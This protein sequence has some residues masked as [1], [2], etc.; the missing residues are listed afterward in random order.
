MKLKLKFN[1]I[2]ALVMLLGVVV[3]AFLMHTQLQKSAAAVVQ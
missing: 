3:S 2:I 1:I